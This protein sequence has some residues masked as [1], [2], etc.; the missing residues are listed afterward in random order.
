M[1]FRLVLATLG[2]ATTALGCQDH[3]MCLCLGVLATLGAAPTPLLG[4]DVCLGMD[5]CLGF[6]AA[7]PQLDGGSGGI[8]L[9][10]LPGI[11]VLAIGRA[12]STTF[13]GFD[14]V[15]LVHPLSYTLVYP[16]REDGCGEGVGGSHC[17]VWV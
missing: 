7:P 5:V 3:L 8:R 14:W 2:A 4:W 11:E 13:L 12:S 6:V 9:R 16:L 1:C 17:L 15:V 10:R